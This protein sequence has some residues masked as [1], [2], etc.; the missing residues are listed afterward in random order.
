MKIVIKLSFLSS[1]YFKE[2]KNLTKIVECKKLIAI[3]NPLSFRTNKRNYHKEK[4]LLYVGRLDQPHKG[5]DRLLYIW[6]KI[7]NDFSDWELIVLGDG[8]YKKP[9]EDYIK[10]IN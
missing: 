5:V 9:M 3:W 7:E 8:P 1:H 2:F 10:K 4:Q 6:N